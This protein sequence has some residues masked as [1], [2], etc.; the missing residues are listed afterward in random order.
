ME[1][2]T[3]FARSMLKLYSN[4]NSNHG[5][6][7]GAA[8]AVSTTTTNVQQIQITGLGLPYVPSPA[9]VTPHLVID[10]SGGSSVPPQADAVLYI[11]ALS[12]VNTLTFQVRLTNTT[13][14]MQVTVGAR[15]N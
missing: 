6:V 13:S 5:V 9:E 8:G 15:L 2:E 3:T 14:P 4:T 7:R 10:A 11:P 1:S 12:S